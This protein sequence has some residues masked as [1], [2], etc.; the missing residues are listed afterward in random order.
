V[1][2]ER[3]AA[4]VE[5]EHAVGKRNRLVD[6]V[7]Y[8]QTAGDASATAPRRDVHA[9][10]RERIERR[11]RFVEQQPAPV[12]ARALARAPRAL[13]APESVRGHASVRWSKATS[14][15]AAAARSRAPCAATPARLLPRPLPRQQP[16]ILKDDRSR[17]RDDEVAAGRLIQ[18]GQGRNSV[19][20]PEP[21]RPSNATNSP[22]R[23]IEIEPG[24]DAIRT[25]CLR[26]AA[27]ANAS[28][29][30][31]RLEIEGRHRNVRCS[32]ART[33]A[34]VPSPSNA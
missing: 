25:K 20:L 24:E 1:E 12:R 9:H 10:A 6:V 19:V 18:A 7:R 15:S 4:L 14:A 30:R 17:L 22:G 28:R 8:Q 2:I 3:D 27:C 5:N 31:R 32:I 29:S 16:R 11:E 23:D 13:L 34:S 26:K 21:L 33:I